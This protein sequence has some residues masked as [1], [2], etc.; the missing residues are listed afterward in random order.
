MSKRDRTIIEKIRPLIKNCLEI[1]H[2]GKE[3][4]INLY[5]LTGVIESATALPCETTTITPNLVSRAIG[6]LRTE[7]VLI[8]SCNHKYFIAQTWDEWVEF[9]ENSLQAT[10]LALFVMGKEMGKAAIATLHPPS[11]ATVD[12]EFPP[13]SLFCP[14]CGEAFAG[15]QH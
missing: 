5:R 9:R 8:L 2:A 10:A 3:K 12:P 6:E 11:K 4:R 7:G 14:H 13:I 15:E 1:F